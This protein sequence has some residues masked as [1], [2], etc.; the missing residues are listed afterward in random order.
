MLRFLVL[1]TKLNGDNLFCFR[2]TQTITMPGNSETVTN[3]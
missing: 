1:E 2:E 3:I